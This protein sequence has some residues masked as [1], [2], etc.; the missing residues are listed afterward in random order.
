M[1]LPI[2]IITSSCKTV[3]AAGTHSGKVYIDFNK[4]GN[5]TAPEMVYSFNQAMPDTVMGVF[6]IPNTA[7]PGVLSMRIIVRD[8]PLPGI[9]NACVAGTGGETEDY[10]IEVASNTYYVVDDGPNAP[11]M[12]PS[13]IVCGNDSLLAPIDSF[14]TVQDTIAIGYAQTNEANNNDNYKEIYTTLGGGDDIQFGEAVDALLDGTDMYMLSGGPGNSNDEGLV[15]FGTL[16]LSDGNTTPFTPAIGTDGLVAPNDG[17]NTNDEWGAAVQFHGI[18]QGFVVG[19]PGK[20]G[21]LGAVYVFDSDGNQ[22]QKIA[23]SGTVGFGATIDIDKENG[24]MIVG[25]PGEGM[26]YIYDRKNDGRFEN[27]FPIGCG[28][29]V[30]GFGKSVSIDGDIAVVGIPHD[31]H[32]DPSLLAN[33]GAALIYERTEIGWIENARLIA[34]EP[35]EGDQFGHAVAVNDGVIIIGAPYYDDG[36]LDDIG[37]IY[38]MILQNAQTI[39]ATDGEDEDKVVITWDYQGDNNAIDGFLVFRD[40]EEI[41]TLESTEEL[42]EDE[43][44]IPGKVYQYCIIAHSNDQQVKSTPFCDLGYILPNGIISGTVASSGASGVPDIRVCANSPELQHALLLNGIDEYVQ[45]NNGD[46]LQIPSGSPFSIAAWAKVEGGFATNRGIITSISEDG[47]NG[48]RIYADE[49]NKWTFEVHDNGTITSV[50]STSTVGL[51][52]TYITATYDGGNTNEL[53]IYINGVLETSNI[54]GNYTPNTSA[55]LRI[56]AGS[57]EDVNNG[58]YFFNG[59]LDD[60][61]IWGAVLNQDQIDIYRQRMLRGN[62]DNLLAYWHMNDGEGN[63][64]GEYSQ[65]FSTTATAHFGRVVGCF[66]HFDVPDI[67]YCTFTDNNGEYELAN[68]FYSNQKDFTVRP[69]KE[70][71]GFDPAT[72]VKE[73]SLINNEQMGVN[74]VDTTVFTVSGQVL[75]PSVAGVQCRAEGIVIKATHTSEPTAIVQPDTTDAFGLYS[76]TVIVPGEYNIVP[77]FPGQDDNGLPIVH[78]FNPSV[79]TV[80]VDAHIDNLDFTDVTSRSLSGTVLGACQ[81][82]IGTASLQLTTVPG[83]FVLNGFTDP[84]TGNFSFNNLPP[85][86]YLL[87]VTNVVKDDGQIDVNAINYFETRAVEVDLTE[88]NQTEHIVYNRPFKVNINSVAENGTPIGPACGDKYVMTQGVPYQVEI[89]IEQLFGLN[90]PCRADSGTLYISDNISG[91]GATTLRFGLPK[92]DNASPQTRNVPVGKIFYTI[93]PGDP[94]IAAPFEK[95]FTVAAVVDGDGAL[96]PSASIEAIINGTKSLSGTFTTSVDNIHLILRDPPGDQ[97]HSYAKLEQNY[98]RTNV[99]GAS[100]LFGAEAETWKKVKI[101]FGAGTFIGLGGG[102]NANLLDI[103]GDGGIFSTITGKIGPEI[104]SEEEICMTFAEEYST[105]DDPILVGQLGDVWIG[106]GRDIFYTQS[107][108]TEFNPSNCTVAVDTAISAQ[109]NS[110]LNMF[111][112][113]RYHI[114]NY[115]IPSFENIM[116]NAT[117]NVERSA[118]TV[119]LERWRE[120]LALADR[121]RVY[122]LSGGN[123]KNP[124]NVTMNT[125]DSYFDTASGEFVELS[126]PKSFNLQTLAGTGEFLD[127]NTFEIL[128]S[129]D[130]LQ[131]IDDYGELKEYF[132]AKSGV[133][134][135]VSIGGLTGTLAASA[136]PGGAISGFVLAGLQAGTIAVDYGI[137][138]ADDGVFDGA[139]ALSLPKPTNYAFN[140]GTTITNEY[141]VSDSYSRDHAMT[142]E[143]E[144]GL[145]F[146]LEVGASNGPAIE[147]QWVAIA[148][149]D[150]KFGENNSTG[151]SSTVGFVLGDSGVD[152]DFFSVD[153]VPDFI[154]G[155]PIFGLKGGRAACPTESN[156]DG[157]L[158]VVNPNDFIQDRDAI[159]MEL[160]TGY[161]AYQQVPEGGPSS[162]FYL[163]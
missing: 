94:N 30:S 81:I 53:K 47:Q 153:V 37:S 23:E 157:E 68:I 156:P 115:L 152:G 137:A 28:V 151:N 100:G 111:F 104:G 91:I 159:S 106:Y 158:F 128:F 131:H 72:R 134:A 136:A 10:I 63:I 97:S 11:G 139:S 127:L 36:G 162:I 7:S 70:S 143:I 54:T 46:E 93:I 145:G 41:A 1:M 14:L 29:G 60:F 21:G 35:N 57:V 79:V 65:N 118:A 125:Y 9:N 163:L 96:T 85:A 67:E 78:N 121:V 6:N 119:D 62:E 109:R 50:Q 108:S 59:K 56:G 15:Y 69:N 58:E 146:K 80:D 98:C 86:N 88:Q 44:A 114:Q 66:W 107:F 99:F 74:F 82:P 61:S 135:G 48:F 154:Y 32:D 89:H 19:A 26:A 132:L 8:G 90:N 40:G 12:Y 110:T 84:T 38:V 105:S 95:G 124:T 142:I 73:L 87:K 123:L 129:Q 51:D 55:F 34:S 3:G 116:Q 52:W 16:P 42:H 148:H 13:G 25:A 113:T 22:L 20:D 31:D 150:Y 126:E 75:Y 147:H 27:S 76:L 43:D 161:T 141:S 77:S 155:T 117:E 45:V 18:G 133:T 101:K 4:D 83:C 112:Y 2:S 130:M 39:A 103:E 144:P 102:V 120:E 138:V 160:A 149:A 49:T 122:S 5:F 33:A 17:L 64:L 92:E 140:A 71:H 24:R